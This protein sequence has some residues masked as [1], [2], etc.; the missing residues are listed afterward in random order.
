MNR[1]GHPAPP[2]LLILLLVFPLHPRVLA[3]KNKEKKLVLGEVGKDVQL[4]CQSIKKDSTYIWKQPDGVMIIRGGGHLTKG[5]GPTQLQSRVDYPEKNDLGNF[6]LTIRSVELADSKTYFCEVEGS[7]KEVQLLVLKMTIAGDRTLPTTASITLLAGMKIRVTLHGQL[8]V[9]SLSAV[10]QGPKDTKPT[11]QKVTSDPLVTQ[12]LGI[13][14][15]GPW[16]CIVSV[17][18]RSTEPLTM[19]FNIQVQG[20]RKPSEIFY[21]VVNDSLTLTFTLNF[22]PSEKNWEMFWNQAGPFNLS[23]ALTDLKEQQN[24]EG[25]SVKTGFTEKSSDHRLHFQVKNLQA[26]HAGSGFFRLYIEKLKWKLEQKVELVVMEVSLKPAPAR[27]LP[28]L[29]CE[30]H[31]PEL[32]HSLEVCWVLGNKSVTCQKQWIQVEPEEAGL[33]KCQLRS[34]N[35][36][37]LQKNIRLEEPSLLSKHLLLGSGLGVSS[38]L[39]LAIGLVVFCSARR[40]HRRRAERVSQIRRL[41]KDNKTCQCPHRFQ[42]QGFPV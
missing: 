16:K 33:W 42:K 11:I 10:L 40:R 34:N 28:D 36:A 1:A 35:E 17:P 25:K 26:Q 9:A 23:T 8:S 37:L 6:P 19:A 2:L 32:S 31:G 20:F 3:D 38:G 41:L 29:R 15:S 18:S 4:P 39:L 22:K 7:K 27:S 24:R 12:P 13:E 21:G 30:L 5:K 14:D